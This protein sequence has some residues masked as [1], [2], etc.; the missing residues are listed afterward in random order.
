MERMTRGFAE[1]RKDLMDQ[2]KDL[3]V[4]SEG[5]S[6]TREEIEKRDHIL[7][8]LEELEKNLEHDVVDIGKRY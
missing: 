8:E 1:I 4:N 6:L 3:A 2:L 7:R 5:R